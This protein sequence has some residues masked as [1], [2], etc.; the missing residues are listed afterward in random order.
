MNYFIKSIK[1]NK[2]F[3]L[4]NFNI[5]IGESTPHLLITGQNGSGKT[6]LLN[7]ISNYIDRIK[8]DEILYFL[9]SF[10]NKA[11][12]ES[13]LK[14][15]TTSQDHRN[16]SIY[17]SLVDNVGKDIDNNFG[18]VQIDFSDIYDISKKYHSGEFLFVFYSAHR[19]NKMQEPIN[20]KKPNWETINS[21]SSTE[22]FLN[23]LVDIKIQEALARNEK[24]IDEAD[25][26]G[27]W[28]T[29]FQKMLGEIYHDQ[30]L[31][32]EFGYKDYSF[33]IKTQG[34]YFKF[35]ELSDGYAAIIE[36][37]ASLILK[38]QTK[39]S[40]TRA[41]LKE[42]IVIIDEIETH[43]HLELQ[44][45]ILPFL[46]RVFPNIQFIISTHSPFILNSLD[47]ATAFDL[48]N[49]ESINE[50]TEY[51]YEALAEGYFGVKTESSYIE[52]KMERLR[53]LL[54]QSI[55]SSSDNIEL[56]ELIID[57]K[58]ISDTALPQIK[59]EFDQLRIQY[60]DKF[61]E[62]LS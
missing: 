39:D 49:K 57:F 15:A 44:R 32:L 42:G 25:Q 8:S 36:I 51:S 7:A 34:R 18:K 46:T 58:T 26:I 21:S 1:V 35:T 43:L 2:I 27:A 3:H 53:T 52:M 24:K 55:L 62:V 50:L 29:E 22:E 5:P 6:L 45:T 28:F 60:S 41:Y 38:M 54:D 30:S 48:E 16:I 12:Y 13:N 47:N 14:I 19:N 10:N 61:K 37:V 59:G 20:P 11:R 9:D 31:T 23:Y 40:N 33:R 4:E 56:K 17:K